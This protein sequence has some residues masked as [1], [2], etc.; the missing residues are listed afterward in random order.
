MSSPD[1]GPGDI[2]HPVRRYYRACALGGAAAGLV[3]AWMLA[4]G[5]L[6]FLQSHGLDGFYDAQADAWLDGRWDIPRER[7]G[8]EAFIVD[9]KAYE[10]FGPFPALLRVPFAGFDSLDGRLTQLSIFAAFAVL[11]VAISR[12][13]WRVRSLA[14]KE[15]VL[16]RAECVAA[17]AFVFVVG[18]GSVVMFLASRPIVYHE[19]E[20]WGAA[21]A[22][23]ALTAVLDF[24]ARP[25][26]RSLAVAAVAARSRMLTRGSVGVAPIVAL[27]IVFVAVGLDVIARRTNWRALA[28]PRR[29]CAVGGPADGP[30]YLGRM[31][32]AVIVPVALYSVVNVA[33]FD[34]PWE[35]PIDKQIATVIDPVRPGIFE[36]TDGSLFAPKFVPTAAWAVFRPD[37]IAFDGVFPFVTFPAR[38]DVIGD[39]TF[40]SVDPAASLPAS[41]PLL[42]V[43]GIVGTVAIWRPRRDGPGL[44]PLRTLTIGGLAAGFGVITIP[45]VNQRY[46]SDFMPLLVV[47]AAAGLHVIVRWA[48]DAPPTRRPWVRAV[49]SAGVAL[50]IVSVWFN[51]GLALQYQRAYSPFTANAERAA[52]V[53]FQHALDEHL[54]G[55]QRLRVRRGSVLPAEPEPAGT[56]FVVGDCEAVYWTDGVMWFPIERTPASGYH[57]LTVTFAERPEGTHETLLLSGP[58]DAPDRLEVVHGVDDLVR[59]QLTSPHLDGPVTGEAFHA[60][61][62][63]EPVALDI[64]YDTRNGVLEVDADGEPRLRDRV[65]PG[66]RAGDHRR[67]SGGAPRPRLQWHRRARPRRDAV[68]RRSDCVGAAVSSESARA[69][70]EE[71]RPRGKRGRAGTIRELGREEGRDTGLRYMPAFDGLRALAVLAV[72]LYHG[73]VSWAGAATS[74][75]TRSSSCQRLPDHEPAARRVAVDRDAID[76]QAFWSRRARRLLP[77]L[78]V[79]LAAVAVYAAI[80]APPNELRPAA[81]RRV[82]DARLRRELEPDLLGP[83]VL[84]PVRGTVAVAAHR[85]RSRSRSSSTCVWP[86]VVLG[87]LLRGGAAHAARSSRR[88]RCS[89]RRRPCSMAVLYEPGRDP[90][91]V[92]YGTDTRAQSL[93]IGATAR[94]AARSTHCGVHR[95]APVAHARCTPPRSSRSACCCHLGRRPAKATAGSTAAG[96]RSRP[97]SCDRHRE[98]HAAERHRAA[99]ALLVVAAAWSIGLIS[100]GL[101]LWHWPI[102]V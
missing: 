33:K 22:I 23:V 32:A 16:T 95:C 79:V 67:N 97:C 63:G 5:R 77:A 47:V 13:L 101:Y 84:R 49:A 9:G 66:A 14:R 99:R 34:H 91:R 86:L 75:S 8:F 85:G 56:V 71:S 81:A 18:A 15:A 53:R 80:V 46:L 31:F 82:R 25:G 96:S 59:L 60:R 4:I 19:A 88:A 52:Y 61:R 12:L 6:D 21:W 36:T 57:P 37:A 7:L 1:R 102:F 48:Y 42:F 51:A 87:L 29:W 98:R 89:R 69:G 68:L 27:G 17:G 30:T 83:V 24:V 11:M 35:I 74:A 58:A 10:Y 72:L 76:L 100:Y 3:F 39:I 38:A 73:D 64:V 44:A 55:G 78:V 43:V 54:P 50:A 28:A 62:Q 41:M 26:G 20:L 70:N 94:D 93:L 92:Y 45:Y 40:A 2:D 90:S 65:P